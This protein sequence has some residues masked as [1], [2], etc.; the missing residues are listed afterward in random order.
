MNA[1][2]GDEASKF[3]LTLR[4][5]DH[6]PLGLDVRGET[7][8]TYLAVDAVLP[9]GAVESWNRLAGNSRDIRAGDR[10][11][12]INKA[13]DVDAMREEC[14]TQHLLRLT[15]LRGPFP[16]P[17]GPVSVATS[18]AAVA[19]PITGLVRGSIADL[20]REVDEFVPGRVIELAGM[21]I[22]ERI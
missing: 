20:R 8:E 6:V 17:A 11:I 13:E 16:T 19:P 5:A 22:S 18:S 9:G 1:E 4:R 10:I 15:V 12:E 3:T 2:R 7:G 21:L 14:R